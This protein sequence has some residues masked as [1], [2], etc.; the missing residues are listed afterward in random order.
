MM[1]F[2]ICLFIAALDMEGNLWTWGRADSGQL[3]VGEKLV[4]SID[5]SSLGLPLPTKVNIFS[6]SEYSSGV[7]LS[8]EMGI[9][10]TSPLDA[11]VSVIKVEV[12]KH[13][14]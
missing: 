9:S 8:D 7:G 1:L 6:A 10:Q 11:S 12:L 14:E 3:G 13:D 4:L 2:V 5:Q